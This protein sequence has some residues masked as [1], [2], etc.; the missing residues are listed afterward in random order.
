MQS[1]LDVVTGTRHKVDLV[2]LN[3]SVGEDSFVA[4]NLMC[5]DHNSLG[6]H[7]VKEEPTVCNLSEGTLRS[8]GCRDLPRI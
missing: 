5:D 8:C 6:F 7:W 1:F 2:A 4:L 3:A